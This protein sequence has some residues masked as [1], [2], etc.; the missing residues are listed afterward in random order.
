MHGAAENEW[1]TTA[2]ARSRASTGEGSRKSRALEL[3]VL[4]VRSAHPIGWAD[5]RH[6]QAQ[7]RTCEVARSFG[8]GA[9]IQTMIEE[10]DDLLATQ[11]VILKASLDASVSGCPECISYW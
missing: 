1:L 10:G 6:S 4:K 3:A 9:T 8:L 11:W 5:R 2:L 7:A